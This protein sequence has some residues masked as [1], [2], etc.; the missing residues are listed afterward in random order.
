LPVE[1]W[2]T[3]RGDQPSLGRFSFWPVAACWADSGLA[4]GK[5]ERE[6]ATCVGPARFE[7]EEACVLLFLFLKILIKLKL[8]KL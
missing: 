5:R 6:Q 7:E 4:M 8:V 2:L 1:L 3:G